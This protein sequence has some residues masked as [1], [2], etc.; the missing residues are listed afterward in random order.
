MS[1]VIGPVVFAASWQ[2]LGVLAERYPGSPALVDPDLTRAA[3]SSSA[4]A[5]SAFLRSLSAP[6]LIAYPSPDSQT[7]SA[8]N[9]IAAAAV[10]SNH[11]DEG[12]EARAVELAILQ[13]IDARRVH[14]LLTRVQ[15]A[16]SHAT[17]RVFRRFIHRAV[18]PCTVGE[19]AADFGIT[20]W[21]LQRRCRRLGIPPPAKLFCLGRVF[22]V[23]RLLLW[24]HQ[25]LNSVAIALGFSDRANCRRLVR[26]TLGRTPSHYMARGESEPVEDV[27]F[28][29]LGGSA[30]H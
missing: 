12:E 5:A 6:P 10:P 15:M 14:Q 26:R 9:E 25:S 1:R 27:I 11:S 7:W 18:E 29:V 23:N 21:T 24:S 2:E 13:S 17:Y 22:T 30:D 4:G 3:A 28:R 20:E 19:L 16:T 8:E